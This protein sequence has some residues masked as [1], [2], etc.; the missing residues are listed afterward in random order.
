MRIT[1]IEEGKGQW[2][3]DALRSLRK[4]YTQKFGQ[5]HCPCKI[6]QSPLLV[7]VLHSKMSSLWEWRH[8]VRHLVASRH[9]KRKRPH[10]QLMCI[11]AQKRLCLRLPTIDTTDQPSSNLPVIEKSIK[12]SKRCFWRNCPMC[13]C[14]KGKGIILAR[15]KGQMSTIQQICQC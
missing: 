9:S 15:I 13:N 4:W 1:G 8:L 12:S 7:N 6:A 3:L 10:L 5:K 14:W 11:F 2:I